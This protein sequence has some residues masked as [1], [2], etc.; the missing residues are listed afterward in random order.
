M[1]HAYKL[2]TPDIETGES[3]VESQPTEPNPFIKKKKRLY[4]NIYKFWRVSS[5]S[6]FAMNVSSFYF[7]DI[8]KFLV[9][10]FLRNKHLEEFLTNC[11]S[12]APIKELNFN[13]ILPHLTKH[14]RYS[15]VSLSIV[16]YNI[17]CPPLLPNV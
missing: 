10:V 5:F 15:A 8:W 17:P 2:G 11:F 1:I 9:Y 4:R 7:T 3:R 14:Q 6:H 12:S 16:D 13:T